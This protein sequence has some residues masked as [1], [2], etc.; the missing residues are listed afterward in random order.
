MLTGAPALPTTATS[1]PGGQQ[2]AAVRGR[3]AEEARLTSR[4]P[5]SQEQQPLSIPTPETENRLHPSCPIMQMNRGNNAQGTFIAGISNHRDTS[6]IQGFPPSAD[7]PK[8][9]SGY[10]RAVIWKLLSVHMGDPETWQHLICLSRPDIKEARSLVLSLGRT[11]MKQF[12]MAL[13]GNH[14]YAG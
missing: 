9:S 7:R 1:S 8:M 6:A 12:Q 5:G 10:Q 11:V 2:R 13:E 3:R 4:E 14:I